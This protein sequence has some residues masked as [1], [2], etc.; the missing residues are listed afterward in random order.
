MTSVALADGK[1]A[2]VIGNSA[3]Q[4]SPLANPINDAK[5]LAGALG[6][7]G[8]EVQLVTDLTQAGMRRAMRDFSETVA[9]KGKDTVALVYYAG[10]GLQIDGENFLVP[11]DA[12]VEREADVAIE[13]MRLADMM[14]AL[15]TLPTSLRIVI[16]DA[17]RNNPFDALSKGGKG[18][19]IVDA[20]TGSIVAY[21]TAPGSEALDGGAAGNSPYTAALVEV[22]RQPNLQIEQMFK[23]V[24]VKVNALTGGKQVPWETSSLTVN[25]AFFGTAPA[26]PVVAAAPVAP[27]QPAAEGALPAAPVAVASTD[28]SGVAKA[29]IESIKTLP[30]ERAYDVVIEENSVE[31]YEEF[32]RIYPEDPRC[33]QIKILLLRRNQMVAWRNAVVSNTPEAYAAYE[34]LYPESDYA[35]SARRLRIQ[36]RLRPIDPVIARPIHLPISRI[37][38]VGGSVGSLGIL[39][40][41]SRPTLGGPGRITTVGTPGGVKINVPGTGTPKIGTIGTGTGTPKVGTTGTGTP[42]LTVTPGTTPKITTVTTPRVLSAPVAPRVLS[43]PSTPK[44]TSAPSTPRFSIPSGGGARFGG[45]G[46]GGGGGGRRR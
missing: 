2:L 7:A 46:G 26:A 19:A 22:L 44:F 45:G 29:R 9:R 15:A 37:L 16:L 35:Y 36:P 39:N 30:A 24:R 1:V 41:G 6:E 4:K 14:N 11:V 12:K 3:Y 5:L 8:F 33:R 31:A 20:P 43:A 34:D 18:L 10:H 23:S 21:S 25:F 28:F 38:K 40:A 32:I 13:T 42:K 27:A 17:C